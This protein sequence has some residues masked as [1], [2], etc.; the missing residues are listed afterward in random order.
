MQRKVH[1]AFGLFCALVFIYLAKAF[2][3]KNPDIL[4]ILVCVSSAYFFSTFPDI[5]MH[6]PIKH[7]GITHSLTFFSILIGIFLMTY[8]FWWNNPLMLW[9]I[10]GYVIGYLAHLVSDSFTEHGIAWFHPFSEKT[11]GLRIFNTG[12]GFVQSIL[13]LL[14]WLANVGM[15]YLLIQNSFP[16]LPLPK[17]F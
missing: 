12:N 4:S 11:F 2:F 7:R 5:D 6:L 1:I 3:G 9:F 14:L 15:L 13:C 8:K 17:P 10:A 16:F